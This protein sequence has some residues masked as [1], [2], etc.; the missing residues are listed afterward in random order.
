MSTRTQLYEVFY[1][2]INLPQTKMKKSIASLT[3]LSDTFY[4]IVQLGRANF[5]I[6]VSSLT[7]LYKMFHQFE[8]LSRAYFKIRRIRKNEMKR[9][10]KNNTSIRNQRLH[11]SEII[12]QKFAPT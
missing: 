4:K 6:S 7:E 2:I 1:E 5:K 8:N 12:F 11:A 9:S 3:Y 10:S